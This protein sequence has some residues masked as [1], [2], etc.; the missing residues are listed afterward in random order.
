[1][2]I[3]KAINNVIWYIST[4]IH[5]QILQGDPAGMLKFEVAHI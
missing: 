5:L 3:V 2:L 4:S 1:M